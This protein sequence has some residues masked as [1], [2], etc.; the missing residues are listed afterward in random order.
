MKTGIPKDGSREPMAPQYKME[1]REFDHPEEKPRVEYS[2]TV[3]KKGTVEN[4]K[5]ESFAKR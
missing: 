1:K 5:V 2:Y 3:G 4:R